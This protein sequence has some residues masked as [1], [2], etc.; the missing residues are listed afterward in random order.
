[1]KKV[2]PKVYK[3]LK[4]RQR[5]NASLEALARGD[6]QERQ[7]LYKT[8]P[9]FNYMLEDQCFVQ[10]WNNLQAFAVAAE[11]DLRGFELKFFI[12]RLVESEDTLKH[13]RHFSNY[14]S[15][16]EM[17]L[18]KSGVDPGVLQAAMPPRPITD[19]ILRPL[20]PPPDEAET[21]MIAEEML[22]VLAP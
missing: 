5:L 22:A 11:C 6:E 10:R 18:K 2:P 4:P 17:A 7:R 8:C 14:R 3:R 15:A 12:A 9:K 21:L 19:E 20:V 1:M 13:L 16:W